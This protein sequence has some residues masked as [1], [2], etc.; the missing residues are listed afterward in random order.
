MPE[1]KNNVMRINTISRESIMHNLRRLLVTLLLGMNI[2]PST[3][4][5]SVSCRVWMDGLDYS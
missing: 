3:T 5:S 2:L 4:M 1:Y